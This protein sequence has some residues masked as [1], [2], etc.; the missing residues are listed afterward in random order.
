MRFSC[1]VDKNQPEIVAALRA[2]G[3]G[4]LD[5]SAIGGGCPDICVARGGVVY[6]IE[7]KNPKTKGKLSPLQKKWHAKFG[8]QAPVHVVYS[9]D[10]ALRVVGLL[11]KREP[12]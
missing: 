1:K 11:K 7:I 12:A 5:L 3:C 9:V 2:S 8:A 10:D 6:L 4:V